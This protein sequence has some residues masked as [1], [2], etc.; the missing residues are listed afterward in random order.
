VPTRPLRRVEWKSRFPWRGRP[1]LM[2]REACIADS[3]ILESRAFHYLEAIFVPSWGL[4]L[5][6][7]AYCP[8][9]F[10]DDNF[11]PERVHSASAS[12][13]IPRGK[14]SKSFAFKRRSLCRARWSRYQTCSKTVAR[15][16]CFEAPMSS[17][18]LPEGR[19]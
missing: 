10:L 5:T 15:V 7:L 13:G 19:K 3:V 6:R 2:P 1:E 4:E 18:D 16:V 17:F 8:N 9:T 14:G 12:G 11:C